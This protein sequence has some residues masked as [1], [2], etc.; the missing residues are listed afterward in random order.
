[1]IIVNFEKRHIDAAKA[2][3]LAN[4]REEQSFVPELPDSPEI[5]DLGWF[6][7]K[8]LGVA[9]MEDDRLVGFLCWVGPFENAFNSGIRGAYVPLHAHGAITQGR[10]RIYQ[11]LYQA[12]AETWVSQDTL[13]HAVTLYAR[14]EGIFKGSDPAKES[15]K[16]VILHGCHT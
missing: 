3:A 5:P 13:S 7:E 11:R 8:G 1:M 9:A 10:E 2:L 15:H 12:A 4:Y 6:A 14:V 16:P